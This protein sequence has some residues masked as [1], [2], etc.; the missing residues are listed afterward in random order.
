MKSTS[1]T[2]SNTTTNKPT[3][4]WTPPSQTHGALWSRKRVEIE[5]SMGRSWLYGAMAEGRFPRP[6][7]IGSG[8]VAWVSSEVQQWIADRISERG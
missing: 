5:T 2:A 6:V 3:K 7:R 1:K 8:R 4:H